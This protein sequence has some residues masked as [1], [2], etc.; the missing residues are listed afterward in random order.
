MWG[1]EK[2]IEGVRGCVEIC[3]DV[4]VE[5]IDL[6]CRCRQVGRLLYFNNRVGV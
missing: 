5:L 6:G 3:S 1:G 2:V 4:L